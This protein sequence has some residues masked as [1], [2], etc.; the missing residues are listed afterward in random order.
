MKEQEKS[1]K[2]MIANTESRIMAEVRNLEA[3]RG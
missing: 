3:K 2:E 1:L